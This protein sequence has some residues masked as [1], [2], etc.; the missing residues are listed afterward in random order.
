MNNKL[1]VKRGSSLEDVV[2]VL[3]DAKAR[4]ESVYCEFEGHKLHSDNITMDS[5]FLE[6]T[7]LDK[8]DYD[9]EQ[10][11]IKRAKEN[12]PVWIKEG[13]ALIFPERHKKWKEC[14]KA[15][16]A[17][18]Y[19][20]QDLDMALDIMKALD[21]G[22]SIEEAQD[23]FNHQSHSSVTD[24]FVRNMIFSFSSRGPEFWEAT[25]YGEISP[26]NREL[27]EAKKQENEELMNSKKS[28]KGRR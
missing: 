9:R 25:A 13:E 17:D 11:K 7:G 8:E 26:E 1:K 10:S 24:S 5:A 3:L 28:R 20:G 21:D 12:I 22:A 6:V 2:S 18:I 4:G 27:L 16:A 14:V 19:H 15:R 23:I